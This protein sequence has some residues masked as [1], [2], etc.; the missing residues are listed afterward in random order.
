[1]AITQVNSR[2]TRR[3]RGDMLPEGALV[4]DPPASSG[5]EGRPQ[6]ELE[7]TDNPVN[8]ELDGEALQ[9]QMRDEI[10]R[11][12]DSFGE[13]EEDEERE[14][15]NRGRGEDEDDDLEDQDFNINNLKEEDSDFRSSSSDSSESSSDS[16]ISSSEDSSGSDSSGSGDSESPSDSDSVG[17]V[18]KD[19]RKPLKELER[20]LEKA[21]RKTEA[22]KARLAKEKLSNK[23]KDKVSKHGKKK[24]SSKD[25]SSSSKKIIKE[26]GIRFQDGAPCTLTLPP[27]QTYWGEAMKNLSENIPLTVLNPT[28]KI[29]KQLKGHVRHVKEIKSSTESWMVALRYDIMVREQVFGHRAKGVPVPDSSIYVEKYE[30][31]ACE[32]AQ[33]RG[34]LSFGDTNPYAKGARFENRD[35]ETGIWN[36]NAAKPSKKRKLTVGVRTS[37]STQRRAPRPS[38]EPR[39]P[40]IIEMLPP[41]Q[42]EQPVASGSRGI[43]R[44]G[45]GGGH[46]GRARPRQ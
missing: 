36:E 28:F 4:I 39:F 5:N 46:M 34:E 33:A 7:G 1:M 21:I 35:P 38:R 31:L 30:K 26:N 20:D 2:S 12:L 23:G 9:E 10:S 6:D 32:K 41:L 44:R 22:M 11:S 25:Q 16:S 17:T 14:G 19:K 27:L 43:A 8:G 40:D 3:T 13:R 29:A 18:K 37:S 45:R 24:K 42:R 15:A